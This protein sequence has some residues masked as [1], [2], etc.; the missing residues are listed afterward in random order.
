MIK[1]NE[2]QR[3]ANAQRQEATLSY[4]LGE[5]VLAPRPICRLL[6]H[7]QR[8]YNLLPNNHGIVKCAC[9]VHALQCYTEGKKTRFCCMHNINSIEH[10]AC[11]TY[12]MIYRFVNTPPKTY[13]TISE[14]RKEKAAH[15]ALRNAVF[16]R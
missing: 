10:T 8:R 2:E 5:V 3:D 14:E 15:T 4:T 1:A 6:R 11:I 12:C 9:W 16:C 13:A 7:R